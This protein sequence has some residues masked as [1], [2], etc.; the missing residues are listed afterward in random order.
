MR[1][2][3]VIGIVGSG[4]PQ[5]GGPPYLAWAEEVGAEAARRGAMVVCGGLGGVME[6]ACR[7]A[8][9]AGGVTVGLLPG[10]D[11][12][13]A[14][15]FVDVPIA[16]GLGE[17]RNWIIVQASDALVAVGGEHGT[18]SEVALALRCGRPVVGLGTWSL[19]RPDGSVDTQLVSAG[20]PREAVEE[21]MAR[22]SAP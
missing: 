19:E 3:C 20:S 18:L 9:G 7:G 13:T 6:A 14:N 22:A 2:S 5:P 17:L 1:S 11:W 10:A 15:R 12:R 21:A 4:E 8:A 16:T